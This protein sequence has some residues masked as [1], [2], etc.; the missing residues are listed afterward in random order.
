VQKFGMLIQP[1]APQKCHHAGQIFRLL[2]HHHNLSTKTPTNCSAM[3]WLRNSECSY[4][5]VIQPYTEFSACRLFLK[6]LGY[7]EFSAGRQQIPLGLFWRHPHKCNI[8]QCCFLPA[9]I[10]GCCLLLQFFLTFLKHCIKN[11]D[12]RECC[13][14]RYLLRV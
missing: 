14:G 7:P 1:C 5:S 4:S 10:L 13:V 12:T 11:F 9:E 3:G 2:N 6:I 8:E